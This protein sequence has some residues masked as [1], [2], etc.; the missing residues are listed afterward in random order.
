MNKYMKFVLLIFGCLLLQAPVINA[1]KPGIYETKARVGFVEGK[2]TN[3]DENEQEKEVVE[4]DKTFPKTGEKVELNLGYLGIG[5][6][7][8]VFILFD[9]KVYIINGLRRKEENK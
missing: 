8:T 7:I 6:I 3:E 1:Q 4:T 5:F 2:T 9:N